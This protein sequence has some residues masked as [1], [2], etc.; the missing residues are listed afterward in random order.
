MEVHANKD[1]A[2]NAKA[3]TGVAL[4]ATGLGVAALTAMGGLGNLF[5]NNGG[6][7]NTN[8]YNDTGCGC[9]S[10]DHYYTRY[11][12]KQAAVIAAKDSEI[13]LLKSEQNTEIKIADVYERLDRQIRMLENTVNANT[14]NQAVTNQQITD[15]IKFVD[16]KFTN[17]YET[18]ADGDRAVKCYVD[19]H[20]VPGKLIMPLDSI[21]PPAEPACPPKT[22]AK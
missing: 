6:C 22:A 20:F 17:V 12:A 19:C 3:N 13:A 2:S 8:W 7:R 10:D 16:S 9:C 14:C 21:C 4:G 5:S 1:Y 11:D 18:I 15:N